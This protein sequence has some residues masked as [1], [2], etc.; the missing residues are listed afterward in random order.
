[1]RHYL[2]KSF[3]FCRFK[4]S[5]VSTRRLRY[6]RRFATLQ[7]LDIKP[8]VV[9][10]LKPRSSVAHIKNRLLQ[11]IKRLNWLLK[12]RVRMRESEERRESSSRFADVA[13]TAFVILWT[14]ISINSP[15]YLRRDNRLREKNSQT[16]QGRIHITH[17]HAR[18][19]REIQFI[20]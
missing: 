12:V 11:L 19:P 10:V 18:T 3:A 20:H 8:D 5:P 7:H 6:I 14:S 9:S 16:I 15:P 2:K 17:S 4:V 13:N 1:M